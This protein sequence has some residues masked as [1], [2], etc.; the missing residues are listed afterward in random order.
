MRPTLCWRCDE[1]GVRQAREVLRLV[2]Q[3]LRLVLQRGDLV[4]DLLEGAGRREHV[5][6]VVL[7]IEDDAEGERRRDQHR[8]D[9]ERC[10]EE[11][12]RGRHAGAA[13]VTD[14]GR[15]HGRI[16]AFSV[17]DGVDGVDGPAPSVSRSGQGPERDRPP[18]R[19]RGPQPGG[20]EAVGAVLGERLGDGG[21]VGLGGGG[22]E[23]ER[24]FGEAELEQPVAAARLAVVVALGRRAAQDLDLPVVQAEAAVDRGDLRLERPLVGQE[25][26]GRAAL[27]DGRRDGAAVD[28]GQRLGG[29]DD[30]R[31]LL[32]QRLQPFAELAGKPAIVEREPALVDDEQGGPAVEAGPRC[33]GRDRRGPRARRRVPISPSVSKACTSASPRCSASASSS[34]PHGPPTVVG[35]QRLLQRV[36]LQQDREAG[37]RPLRHRRRGKRGQRGP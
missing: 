24:H 23:G 35:L 12:R 7:R 37:E 4:V 29:E 5:L 20:G 27:D 3:H 18:S 25:Q 2:D 9:R 6:R 31:V 14:G 21:L 34:R 16:F 28:V 30:G 13:E 26:P 17:S 15:R 10:G 33:D 1:R 36:G 32:A 22:G 8:A 19:G 11:K